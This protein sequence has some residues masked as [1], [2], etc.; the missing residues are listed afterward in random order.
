MSHDI[1]NR[2]ALK[3]NAE[4]ET[5]TRN[6][7]SSEEIGSSKYTICGS[8]DKFRKNILSQEVRMNFN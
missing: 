6:Q 8:L 1:K 3:R 2:I 5:T 7:K 4:K